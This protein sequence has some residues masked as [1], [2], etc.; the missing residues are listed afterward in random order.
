VQCSAVDWVTELSDCI[1]SI[2][3]MQCRAVQCSAVL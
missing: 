2:N 3:A 1:L